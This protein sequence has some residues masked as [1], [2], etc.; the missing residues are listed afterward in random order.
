MPT[1]CLSVFDYFVGLAPKGSTQPKSRLTREI[2]Y[3]QYLCD[4]GGNFG[5]NFNLFLLLFLVTPCLVVAVHSC[6]EWIPI[7]NKNKKNLIF[8]NRNGLKER[9]GAKHIT[10]SMELIGN[11]PKIEGKE[12][13]QVV[14]TLTRMLHLGKSSAITLVLACN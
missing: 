4:L 14:V 9:K 1:N 5:G 13:I 8:E 6:M 10:I 12:I 11:S 2:N 3:R 7:K